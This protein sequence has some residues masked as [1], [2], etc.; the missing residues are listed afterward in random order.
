MLYEWDGKKYR[1]AQ[2]LDRQAVE[3][4]RRS[5]GSNAFVKKAGTPVWR[6]FLANFGDPIIQ[7][8]L[9]V[10]C[11]NVLF[12]LHGSG[13][14]ETMGIAAAVLVSTL[15]STIS[16]H[17][18]ESAFEKLMEEA[19]RITCRVRREGQV[20]E[21][22]VS[23]VV[24]GDLILLQ[25]GERVPA[26][27]C[28][29]QGD[30]RADQSALNGES[31]EVQ[32]TVGG[33]PGETWDLS[34]Q[35]QLFKGS[36]IT[37]GEGLLL[38]C[39]VGGS[40]F[41]G[42][43]AGELQMETRESP[44]KLKLR[45]LAGLL[46]RLGYL[47]AVL[48]ALADLFHATVMEN[49]LIP[50]L[51]WQELCDPQAMLVHFIHALTLAITIVVVAV[52]EGLPM[53]ITVVL[54]SNVVRM[55]RDQVMVRRLVGI[56]TAGGIHIL[57][58]DKT[59]TLTRGQLEV[60]CMVDGDGKRYESRGNL[61]RQG[62]WQ[63]IQRSA[64]YNT[65]SVE[66]GGHPV[67]GNAT[68]RALMAYALPFSRQEEWNI[69]ERLP[70][71]SARKYAAVQLQRNGEEMVLVKGAPEKLLHACTYYYD[72]SGQRRPLLHKERVEQIW[73]ELTGQRQRV[74]VL[75]ATSHPVREDGDLHELCLIA[76]AGI[77]DQL[78]PQVRS[79]VHEVQRAGVQV[80]MV[81]GDN[82]ETA[83]AIAQDAG[84]LDGSGPGA[85]V[86]SADLAAMDDAELMRRLPDFRVV[87]RALPTDKS[88]LVDAAQHRGM[89]AAMT[90]D[91]INDAPALRR[92]D[93][94]FAMGSGTEV[95]KEAGDIVIMDDNFASIVRAV[96]YGRTIFRSIQRF[97]VFQM[98]MNLCAVGLSLIGP[99][100]GVDTPITVIQ[101][102]WC[103]L[104]MDT[105]AGLAFA[106]EPP[107]Q[108]SMQRPPVE[109]EEPVLSR[110]MMAEILCM[111]GA[112]TLLC[113]ILLKFSPLQQMFPGAALLTALFGVFIFANVCNSFQVRTPRLNILQDI[114][115]NP[116]FLGIMSLVLVI[117][118]FLLYRG[119][120]L[121]RTCPLT[122]W[123]LAVVALLSLTVVPI[124]TLCKLW[125]R[126]LRKKQMLQRHAN[127]LVRKNTCKIS[128]ET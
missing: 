79:A 98:T 45:H 28:L 19:E 104:I 41:Y 73:R 105:L 39:R 112:I 18:S 8:L 91:G 118:V 10:L 92:A 25:A 122:L 49:A 128:K 11:I 75:A 113:V 63:W 94:G 13:W 17:G 26:D 46:S 70:F 114:Q 100:I 16:E 124:A 14:F 22:P 121:F 5:Y 69:I 97:I 44:L 89:V 21:I 109:R 67:G 82:R 51:I 58:T 20:Q 53:M 108:E 65:D 4:S 93:V 126:W 48:I 103:N 7:I 36:V 120:S 101:M 61:R 83:A 34:N 56:E 77:R 78:R 110:G 87:A 116:L 64:R 35:H 2:G 68:D 85:V 27:G 37:Q 57:F 32:K 81:T 127:R 24:A 76:L 23:Q 59:G 50:V 1:V 9:V 42:Q 6:Q 38:V 125:L 111:G 3:Q 43:M 84:L 47:A 106:G 33:H 117:Q 119:G 102:L 30:V 123:Q 95:A 40:T 29:L 99:F 72:G 86:T 55:L 31:K 15:V 62:L 12:A 115:R 88:R 74:L 66:S 71:D 90:G 52:P 54:S 107:R 96:L 80:V 60:A